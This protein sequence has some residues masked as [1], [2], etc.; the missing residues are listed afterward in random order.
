MT[1][2]TSYRLG[3]LVALGTALVLLFGVAALG[4]VGDG[5]PWD[6]LYLGALAVGLVGAVVARFRAGGM[7]VALG[8]TAAATLVAGLVALVVVLVRDLDASV[9]DLV[10]LTGMFAVLFAVSAWL[11]RRSATLAA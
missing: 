6:L 2:T 10:G 9:L 5:G 1:T 7:A 11:F 3:A 4:I 8:A